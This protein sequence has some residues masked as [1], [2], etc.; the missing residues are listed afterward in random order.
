MQS[1]KLERIK[2]LVE[3]LNEASKAYYAED[4]EIMSN[5]EYDALYDELQALEQETGMVLANSPT[6]SVGYEA[7]DELPKERHETPMLSLGKTKDREELQNW[8]Q[9][10]PAVLSWKLDGLTIV[11]S[12][13]A[14]KLA[15]AVTRGNGEIGE[16]I[17]NNAKTFVNLPMTIPYTGDLVLRGE[18]VISYTDFEKINSEIEDVDAKYKNPR[19]LCSGSVRQLNNEITAK[20]S[21]RFYAFSLVSAKGSETVGDGASAVEEV[22]RNGAEPDFG[23]SRMAEYEF[24]KNQGFEVVEHYLVTEATIQDT[25]DLFAKKIETYDIPSDGLVMTYEDIAYGQSLGRTAKFPRHSIAFKW[26]DELRETTLKEIEWSASRTGLINPVAIFEPVELEGTTVS[27]A[28]VHNISI[29]RGLKLGLGDRITVYKANMIIPQI[30]ENLTGSNTVEI[31]CT[32]PVC[33]GA[34]EIRKLNE[35]QSLYCT[36]AS[37]AAKQVK[38]FTLFVSRDAMNIEG[39]SEATL[40]KFID[41]GFISEFADLFHLDRYRDEIVA[42]EGFGEKSYNNLV[43]SVNQA[44]NTTLPRVIYALGIANIGVANAK[45]LCKHFGYDLEKMQNADVETL[46]SIEGVGEV[47][48]TAYVEY[49]QNPENIRKIAGLMKELQVEMPVV[50]AGS[51]TLE[52]L[53]FVITGSLNHF[54]N[55]NDLKD[56]IEERGGKVI[57]SVSTK[58][59]ALINNDVTS[60]SSKNKKAKE[61]GI[62]IL[63]EEEFLTQYGITL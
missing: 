53:N 49:M 30:A 60:N 20:R 16:V 46:S 6:V 47:I 10:N 45:M 9:G 25:I 1:E 21:V 63:S 11:L 14:G 52:G 62:P 34:T 22:S 12:Y 50:T 41:M 42:M 32:C 58:T 39:L 28:S 5:F 57:G 2:Y 35:V 8:L 56:L 24:L 31:P 61:L 27:R 7:V 38:S 3:R 15:K 33:G 55:R 59:T 36:N 17:T 29:L 23:N 19:N 40:E 26:A 51:Q 37:C 18:A 13:H 54:A 43:A 4:R 48:A 44:R